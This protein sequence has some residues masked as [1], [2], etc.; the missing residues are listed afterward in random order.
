MCVILKSFP[1]SSHA[2]TTTA[3][4][5]HSTCWPALTFLVSCVA[6]HRLCAQPGIPLLLSRFNYFAHACLGCECV[7]RGPADTIEQE[8]VL[9]ELSTC[10]GFLSAVAP[11]RG[12]FRMLDCS[13]APDIKKG[14]SGTHSIP[15]ASHPQDVSDLP[16]R[17]S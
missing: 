13:I 15:H 1:S 9:V 14:W 12:T 3:H 16:N 17:L 5:I 10:W 2:R 4:Q 7:I 11:L 8:L 6:T